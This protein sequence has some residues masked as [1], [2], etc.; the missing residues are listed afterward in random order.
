MRVK[1]V[2]PLFAEGTLGPQIGLILALAAFG[3]VLIYILS[4]KNK[5]SFERAKQLPLE[6]DA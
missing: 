6:D 5:A 3:L 1:L 4:R 2:A